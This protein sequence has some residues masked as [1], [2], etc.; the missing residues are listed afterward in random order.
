[1]AK[2]CVNLGTLTVEAYDV[3]KSVGKKQLDLPEY[4]LW[5]LCR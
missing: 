4:I 3:L 1:M 2:P 5:H